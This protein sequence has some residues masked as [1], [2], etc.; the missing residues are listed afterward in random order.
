[1]RLGV[2]FLSS[3]SN[4][5]AFGAAPTDSDASIVTRYFPMVAPSSV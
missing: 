3:S 2:L 4:V 5:A 1:M